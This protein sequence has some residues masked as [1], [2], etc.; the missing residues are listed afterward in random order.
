MRRIKIRL[1]AHLLLQKE[2][3]SKLSAMERKVLDL[4][5]KGYGYQK[6]AEILGKTPKSADNALQRIRAKVRSSIEKYQN[7]E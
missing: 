1:S 5:L 2:I 4:Y 7:Q 3:K 6:I